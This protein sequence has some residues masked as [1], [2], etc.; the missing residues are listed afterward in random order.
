[1]KPSRTLLRLGLLVGIVAL[2]A[3]LAGVAS[4]APDQSLVAKLKDN[5]RGSVTI[6]QRAGTGAAGF[7]RAGQNGDLMPA[8]KAAPK[9]KALG[10]WRNYGAIMGVGDESSL[11]ETSSTTDV[12]GTTHITYQQSYKGVPVFGAI[13]K[14]HIDKDG[15]LTGVNGV[16]VPNISL[17]THARLSRAEAAQNAIA[18]VVADPPTDSTTGR[19]DKLSASDLSTPSTTLYVYR[20]G[21]VRG[22]P[23]SSQLVYQVEVTNAADVR[24][25]VFVHAQAG[26]IVNRYSAASDALHR[27]VYEQKFLPENKIW[28]E[29]D[30]FPGALNVDQQNIVNFSGQAYGFF[31][32]SFGRDSYDGAGH[33]MSTVNNDPRINCPNANWNGL[34]TNYCNGVTADDVVA[35]EWGHAYT[36][37]TDDLIYQWQPGALNESYSDIW[38]ETVDQLNGVQTDSPAT[39]RTPSSC[40]T[41]TVPIPILIINAPT[42][43]SCP[44]GAAAFGPPLTTTGTTGDLV[45]GL[46]QVGTIPGDT[47]TT[48]GCTPLTNAA[49]VAGKIALMDRGACTFTTKVKNAQNAG[50]IAA[51]IANNNGGGVFGLGGGDATITIPSLGISNAN[52]DLLKGYIASAT[53]NVTLK[54]KGGA[55]PPQDSYK[56]LLSEDATAF[57]PTAPVGG[58]AIRDMWD[59]TCLADP[60]KVTDAEYQ[61]DVSDGG[62]V[63][64]NSGV[65]NHG[66]AL[67]VDGGAYNGQTVIGIGLTKAAHIFWRAQSVYLGPASGF[68]DQADAL[69]ASC[70]DLIGQPLNA[71]SLTA[72]G[73][74][75]QSITAGDCAQV[76]AMIA[77]VEF[78]H[79]PTQQCGFKPLLDPNTPQLCPGAQKNPA[80]IW[81]EDFEGG[82]GDWTLTNQGK[83]AGWP[84]TNWV[85]D[86]SLP[87]GRSGSAAFAEDLDGQCDQNGGDRSG[88]MSMTSPAVHLPAAA[89]QSPRLTFQHYIASELN[90]DGGNVKISING[91]AWQIVPKAAFL[92]NGYNTTLEPA[93]TGTPPVPRNTNPMAGEPAFSGTDGGLVTGTWGESQVDLTKAGAKPGDTIQLRFD[94]GMDGC[95]AIDGW[96]IDDVKVQ[97]CNT[98]KAPAAASASFAETVYRRD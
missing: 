49:A 58:H 90:F 7:V 24:E 59:P 65:N 72:S 98:N 97:A 1:M 95:G 69:E 11:V 38:G 6:S 13:L 42:P 70:Q 78:R 62:G 76:T 68:D 19:A 79:D 75:G 28:E 61:C 71:L 45:V 67:L 48:N 30:A 37:F 60:G 29:G 36:Q 77:A 73:P 88:F 87:G 16:G 15:N 32:N 53:T 26:K 27:V 84:G 3:A 92:F 41:H 31:F 43:G 44:A 81:S 34:T 18:E 56:W 35:H 89:I 54:V 86:S 25:F 83:Y 20:M 94:F 63:H 57:N 55:N 23:G 17:D 5:A 2:A 80:T 66:Y 4:G 52:G 9:G 21:L 8:D 64:T 33:T 40:S 93:T 74:S 46:D 12:Y 51:V 82:L 50:A 22:V 96:Y 91:G 39:V 47:S 85:D 14:A 10:F